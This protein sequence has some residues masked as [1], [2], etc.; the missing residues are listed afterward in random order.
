MASK[1][2]SAVP[3]RPTAAT[4]AP[5]DSRYFGRN[6]FQSSSPRPTRNTAPEAATTL[7]SNPSESFVRS[8]MLAPSLL[9]PDSLVSIHFPSAEGSVWLS[10]SHHLF[11]VG[12]QRIV[13]N[14][15]CCVD[16]VVV[17]K[18]QAAK[19]FRDGMQSSAFRLLP[20]RVVGVRPIYDLP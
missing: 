15:L 4:L 11:A 3:K 10:A 16:F 9:F 8:S 1:K 17:R 6:F 20:Q 18:S 2:S 19:P 14:P 13:D 12:V 7:R 5:N